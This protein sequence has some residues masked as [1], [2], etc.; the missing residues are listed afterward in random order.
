MS[1]GRAQN[2]GTDSSAA[3]PRRCSDPSD[4]PSL[5]AV[6]RQVRAWFREQSRTP[7]HDSVN[8]PGRER[9]HVGMILTGHLRRLKRRTA[10]ENRGSQR[11]GVRRWDPSDGERSR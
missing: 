1:D 5:A 6:I 11:I 9:D 3:P 7:D 4:A 2:G 8:V 10:V